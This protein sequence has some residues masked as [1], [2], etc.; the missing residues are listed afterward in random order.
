[1]KIALITEGVTDQIILRPIIEAI[2]ENDDISFNSVQ[3][4]LDEQDMQ[5]GY[6]GW[7]LVLA[8]L[9]ALDVAILLEQNDFVVVQID[10]DVSFH[11]QFGV[12]HAKPGEKVDPDDL[13]HRVMEKLSSQIPWAK[14][15]GARNRFLYAIG[16]HSIEC[17]LI[18]LVDPKHNGKVINGCFEKLNVALRRQNIQPI[19]SNAKNKGT[20]RKAYL[21]LGRQLGKPKIVHQQAKLNA[22]FHAFLHQLM[23][24]QQ[25]VE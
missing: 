10:T 21:D 14:M 24:L 2:L 19:S 11:E 13:C 17:W 25:K 4:L 22:G 9:K 7:E 16:V 20:S 18:G 5:M 12:Q 8:S 3:P 1:M 6:G 15:E 23:V